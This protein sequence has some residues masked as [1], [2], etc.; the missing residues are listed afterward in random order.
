MEHAKQPHHKRCQKHLD[1]P[2][3]RNRC[4]QCQ[5]DAVN[6]YNHRIRGEAAQY[7][8]LIAAMESAV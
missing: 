1:D 7:R 3:S 2:R 4:G 5:R 6:K 8:A